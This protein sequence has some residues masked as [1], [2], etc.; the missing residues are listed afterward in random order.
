MTESCVQDLCREVI[1][2]ESNQEETTKNEGDY[3]F[4][5]LLNKVCKQVEHFYK[6]S[7]EETTKNEGD[8]NFPFLFK[9]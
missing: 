1:K 8:C 4:P 5:F 2:C 6:V 7:N 9:H 3:H